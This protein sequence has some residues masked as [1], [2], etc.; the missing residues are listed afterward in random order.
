MRAH[1]LLLAGSLSLSLACAGGDPE[2]AIDAGGGGQRA[3]AGGGNSALCVGPDT[4]DAWNVRSFCDGRQRRTETCAGGCFRGACSDTACA[5]ECSLGDVRGA[6]TCRLWQMA[7]AGFVDAEPVGSLHDRAREHER[8]L[9]RDFLT[10]GGGLSS[11]AHYTDTARATLEFWSDLG[12][13]AIWT[14]S[15]LAA[16]AWRLHA[17]GSA[18]AAEQ[19]RRHTE[20][21]HRWFTITGEPG[22]L[23]RFAAPRAD[24]SRMPEI[25]D[26]AIENHHCVQYQGEPYSW[27]GKVSRD[28]YTGVMLGYYLAYHATSDPA[29]RDLIRTD[30]VEIARQLMTVRQV[31]AQVVVDGVPISAMLEV[32]NVILIPSEMDDG[33]IRIEVATGSVGTTQIRGVREFLPDMGPIL[34]QLP[35]LGWVPAVPRDG[36]A[37]MISAFFAMALSMTDG[38]AGMA[39]V[40]DEMRTY[41]ETKIDSWLDIA[42]GWSFQ[43]S[44]GNAYYATHI[45]YI[46]G[47]VH[48]LAETD[49]TLGARARDIV[50]GGRMWPAVASHKNPY[51][52]LLWAGTRRDPDAG[53][54]AGAIEQLAQFPPPPRVRVAQNNEA[55]YPH[56]A[57]CTE[58]GHPM[59]SVDGAVD[60]G[61]RVGDGFLWQRG[62]WQL[63]TDGDER[64]AYSGV[65]YLGA[66]WAGRRHDLIADDRAGTCARF[67]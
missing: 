48:A 8:V 64:I 29:V 50:L 46:M 57:S 59:C 67:D 28:Q 18:D 24:T 5:D 39:A 10:P 14:G 16:E 60:V 58:G 2:P 65:D 11:E 33:K 23:V 6:Q 27:L 54:V 62:P 43:A 51:F 12:D 45:S 42:T 63:Y 26:C 53:A 22:H 32:E 56:D 61:D 9:R 41:Y 44:C 47:Y 52:A 1:P 20:T 35:L 3:D 15:L 7:T 17:T 31:P 49:P 66:Y 25:G 4:C 21:L 19:V 38:V 36:S 55:D 40:H 37:V 30:V 13:S 34:R